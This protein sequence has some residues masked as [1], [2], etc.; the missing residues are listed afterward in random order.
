[1]PASVDPHH[2]PTE[3]PPLTEW[4]TSEADLRAHMGHPGQRVLDKVIPALDTHC[5][6]FIA[7]SPFLLIASSDAQG[8]MD[9]SP[10]GDPAGFV[11]ILDDQTLAIPDR[12][13]NRRA[14]TLVNLLK[15]P[16]IGLLFVAPG[17]DETLR[18]NGRAQIACDDWLLERLAVD[19]KKPALAMVVTVEEAFM[20]CGKCMIR[21]KLWQPDAWEDP[22]LIPS[23]AAIML[24]HARISEDV[25][26]LQAQIDESYRDRLY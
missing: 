26:T 21:S 10:K 9:V 18:V 2:A 16:Q 3:H 25:A 1:M 5:R 4:I 8:R 19:G 15:N 17:K 20:H 22:N 23:L 11:Q 13:G 6:T 24:D 7:Q 12:P 14:D